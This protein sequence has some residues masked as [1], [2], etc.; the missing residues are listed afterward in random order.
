MTEKIAILVDSCCDIPEEYLNKA[1]IYQ[2]PMQIIYQDKTYLDRVDIT[3]K[4]VYDNLP[5]EIPKTSLPSGEIIQ[6]TL[7]QISEDG[8][9]HIISISVSSGLSGTFNFVKMALEDD[10][11]FISKAYD[12]KQVAVASGL[13]A[14][15]AKD[16]ID[17][18]ISFLEL[19][20]FIQ[21]MIDNTLVYFC[22]PTLEYLKAGGRIGKVAS[23][24]GCMLKLAPIITCDPEGIYTVAAKA[25]G[26]KK[27][28][29]MMLDLISKFANTHDK[30]LLAVGH[31]DDEVA[32]QKMLD[33][34]NENKIVGQ[35]QFLGQVGPALG[36]HTGPGLVGVAVCGID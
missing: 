16:K 4:E 19:E 25:R 28:Q 36:V 24:V 8:Y 18:G 14:V 20:T 29:K 7:N 5:T 34:L 3:A 12:T 9:D 23:F 21:K 32:G 10:Q 33:L 2:I 26:M 30:Y 35:K 27:G 1:G 6:K 13:I 11:R 15:G 22:I 17:A 31:G